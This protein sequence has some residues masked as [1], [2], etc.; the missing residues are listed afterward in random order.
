MF[1]GE[2]LLQRRKT[3]RL[4]EEAFDSTADSKRAT[5]RG[6]R[7]LP[8]LDPVLVFSELAE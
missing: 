5:S 7:C 8:S 6:L 3:N 1:P 2:T 4:E